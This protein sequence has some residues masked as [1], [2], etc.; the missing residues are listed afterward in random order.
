MGRFGASVQAGPFAGM[1]LT[2]MT[3]REHLGPY[4]L[5]IYES[6]LHGVW[7]EIFR[8]DFRQVVDIGAKFGYYAVGLARRFPQ[9]EAIAFDT[10]SWARRAIREMSAANGAPEM[11]ILSFCSL[12]WLRSGLKPGAFILSD[13]EGY[14]SVLFSHADIPALR[15]A[16]MIIE[17]HEAVSP[18][19]EGGI[20]RAFSASHRI[21]KITAQA[22]ASPPASIADFSSEEKGLAINEH[23]ASRQSW[24]YLAPLD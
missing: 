21:V 12:D 8:G 9:A 19:V 14:E 2:P 13:C 18:G 3:F 22:L 10:D 11:R 20:E 1:T 5:G 15:S 24:L 17:V 23:R 4:L 6:E 7:A 16:T